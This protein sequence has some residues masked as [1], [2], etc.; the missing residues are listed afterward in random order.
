MKKIKVLIL[1]VLVLTT[2]TGC[3]K[4]DNMDNIKVYTTTYPL[5]YLVTNIYGYNSEIDS[6]YPNNININEYKL[7]DKQLSNYSKSDMFIYNGLSEEKNIAAD[8]LNKNKSIKLIDV[9]RGISLQSDIEELW[10]CPSNY[11]KLAQNIKVGLTNYVNSNILK[12]EIEN[13]YDDLKLTISKFDAELKIVADNSTNKTIIAGNDVFK[14]LEKYGFTVLSIEDN[15][16]FSTKDYNKAKNN[17]VNGTNKYIFVLNTD[18]ETENVKALSDLGA[19]IITVNSMVSLSDEDKAENV[20]YI[21]LMNS[22]IDQIKSEV[23][24]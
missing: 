16:S 5:E 22:F 4:R 17:I 21:D 1:G 19:T 7:T 12:T 6:I 11:L 10:L 9:T 20:D 13:H 24:N 2:L 15:E 14:F 23:Y 3:F 8:L 18:A